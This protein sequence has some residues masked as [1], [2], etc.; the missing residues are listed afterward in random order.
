MAAGITIILGSL[1]AAYMVS[2]WALLVAL[3]ALV[4]LA[5]KS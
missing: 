1:I 5:S 3:L 4:W 2:P